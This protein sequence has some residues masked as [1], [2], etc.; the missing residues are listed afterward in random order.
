MNCNTNDPGFEQLTDEIVDGTQGL[1]TKET[2]VD[3][4]K[5]QAQKQDICDTALGLI[6]RLLQISGGRH[7]ACEILLKKLQSQIKKKCLNMKTL[8]QL[9]LVCKK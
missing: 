1:I 6:D 8:K 5:D 2:K 7:I 3:E 9:T 4:E